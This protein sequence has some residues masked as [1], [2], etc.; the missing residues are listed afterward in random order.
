MKFI[1]IFFLMLLFVLYPLIFWNRLN[2]TDVNLINLAPS[3]N[4]LS[5]TD[6][7][8]RDFFLRCIQGTYLSFAVSIIGVLLAHILGFLFGSLSVFS[9]M[10]LRNW[11]PRVIDMLDTIPSY[12]VVCVMSI[13]WQQF[14]KDFPVLLKSLLSVV[15]S[16]SLVSWMSVSRL[17]RMEILQILDKEYVLNAKLMGASAFDLMKD[18]FSKQVFQ[19]LIISIVQHLPHFILIESFMSYLGIGLVPPY[20]SLGALISEGWKYAFIKPQFFL[21]PSL[22]LII[23]SIEFKLLLNSLTTKLKSL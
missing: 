13:F 11:L 12:L 15:L 10:K 1:N 9:I 4:Y 8:G 16:V 5:G 19:V 23:I 18:H 20:L 21:V 7:L 3:L 17:V 6:S 2:L 22:F 14:F